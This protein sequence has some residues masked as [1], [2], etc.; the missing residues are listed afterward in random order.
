MND[1]KKRLAVMAGVAALLLGVAGYVYFGRG[2]DNSIPETSGKTIYYTGPMK[3]KG[4]SGGYGT[5]DGQALSGEDGKAA[6]DKWLKEH[7]E[8]ATGGAAPKPASNTSGETNQV[9]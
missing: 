9:Q 8:L 2:E 1:E 3:S 6:A 7:P 4:G 5:L